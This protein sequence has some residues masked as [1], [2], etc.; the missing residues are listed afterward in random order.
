MCQ[1]FLK[2]IMIK[3][4]KGGCFSFKQGSRVI[5]KIKRQ[6]LFPARF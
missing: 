5:P 4:K 6:A 3:N 1:V 2:K